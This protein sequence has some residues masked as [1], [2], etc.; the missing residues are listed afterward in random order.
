VDT[1]QHLF[2][3][4]LEEA[5]P[6]VP[7]KGMKADRLPRV[8]ALKRFDIVK[9]AL[10][11]LG[12]DPDLIEPGGSI[13]REKETAGDLDVAI[14]DFEKINKAFYTKFVEAM[15]AKG[16]DVTIRTLGEYQSSLNIDDFLVELKKA[17]R[18]S[19]GSMMMHITGSGDFNIQ[20]RGW[21]KGRGYKL[22]QYGLFD[23][24]SGK[25]YPSDTEEA[26]FKQLGI[27]FIAPKDRK[28]FT[29]PREQPREAPS[30]PTSGEPR[31]PEEIWVKV[32]EEVKVRLKD[33]KV[34]SVDDNGVRIP[35]DFLFNK[36][37]RQRYYIDVSRM[38]KS[39]PD[40]KAFEFPAEFKL[41][42]Y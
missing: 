35:S 27:D 10:V 2:E 8:D 3:Y 39:D 17:P 31:I 33:F 1:F 19:Y 11:E 22:N 42:R 15:R 24:E 36:R 9:A 41:D 29:P 21:S 4:L 14:F 25:A 23:A 16:H 18:E 28:M 40:V 13:R 5:P 30:A 32:P 12:I 38:K 20:L 7:G 6:L 34:P 26:I 37:S